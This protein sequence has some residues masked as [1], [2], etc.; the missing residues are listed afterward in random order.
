MDQFRS[1]K[2]FVDKINHYGMKSGIVKIIPPQ[3][4]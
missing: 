2:D 3:E 4:W 1:F